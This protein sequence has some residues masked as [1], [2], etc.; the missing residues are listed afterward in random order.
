MCRRK[1]MR[2]IATA[3]V[4]AALLSVVS[5]EPPALSPAE[6]RAT[7]E[8]AYTFGYPLVLMAFT[9][10]GAPANVFTHASAF[11]SAGV[12]TVVRPNA[13]TLYSTAW[14]D[15]SKEPI[16][17]HVPDTSGRFYVMQLMDAWTETFAVPGKRTTGTG[18][19]RFGIVGP[20]WRGKLPPGVH[21]LAAPTNMVWLL[22]RTQTNTAADYENVRRIQKGFT[23]TLLSHPEPT[24]T[25]ST[26]QPS[27]EG[28]VP[29]PARVAQ[30]SAVEFFREFQRLLA[31]NPPH[32][33][34]A[35]TVR[36]LAR[37]GLQA[38]ELFEPEKL[39]VEGM[40]ALEEGVRAAAGRL[41]ELRPESSGN[42]WAGFGL[43]IGRYGTN[44]LSRAQVARLGL[45]ALPP[46]DAVYIQCTADK[47]GRPLN[48][49]SQY[50]IHFAPSR[51][52]PVQAFWSLTLYDA[53]GYFVANPLERYAIGDRDT[54]ER[55]PDGSLD[56]WIQHEA[57]EGS[58]AQNWLPAPEGGFNL[59]LRL[60][61]P[62]P[63]ALKGGWTPPAVTRRL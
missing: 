55:N 17:L 62:K 5:A 57:P 29:P 49:G 4:L 32:A 35:P 9:R 26:T 41:T 16:L 10:N 43:R 14:L 40:K 2:L 54:L 45:G 20:R 6:I 31:L 63:E 15:L 7:A 30:L 19:G 61:S 52:P 38:G 56:V 48:G 50:Q 12:R 51:L 24:P 25:P 34:D 23:L 3:L 46:E 44:Y 13:D 39:G 47:D 53:A 36:Q 60:Y 37:L 8:S 58:K 11:P 27:G 42:G 59:T 18:E 28:S 21:S 22:G 33:A 1:P